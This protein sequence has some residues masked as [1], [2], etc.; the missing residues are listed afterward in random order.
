MV[1]MYKYVDGRLQRVDVPVTDV[2]TYSSL[3]WYSSEELAKD[4]A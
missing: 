1:T 4:N 2:S 3:G